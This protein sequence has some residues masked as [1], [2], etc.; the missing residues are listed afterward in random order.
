MGM[1]NQK[2]I[3]NGPAIAE[4][5][6]DVSNYCITI[7][8]LWFK[9]QTCSSK[10]KGNAIIASMQSRMDF[11]CVY[12]IQILNCCIMIKDNASNSYKFFM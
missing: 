2:F 9:N 1:I 10:N 4:I 12:F 11:L 8:W 5:Y 3:Q 6:L 7:F